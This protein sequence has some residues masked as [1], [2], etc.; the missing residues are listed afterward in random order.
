MIKSKLPTAS[1]LTAERK[2]KLDTSKAD[3]LDR[4]VKEIAEK[5]EEAHRHG[6]NSVWIL[7]A[8]EDAVASLKRNGFKVIFHNACGMFD[9]DSHEIS[10]E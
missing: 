3:R 1:K 4:E 7:S 9:M 2:R 8:T 10:W 6:K 5:I